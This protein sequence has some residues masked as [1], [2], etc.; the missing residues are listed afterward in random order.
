MYQIEYNIKR[1]VEV[2]LLLVCSKNKYT[3]IYRRSTILFSIVREG[4]IF[5]SSPESLGGESKIGKVD[6]LRTF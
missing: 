5:A 3:Y 2:E 4:H 6:L 1:C